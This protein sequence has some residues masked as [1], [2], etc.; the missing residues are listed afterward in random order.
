MKKTTTYFRDLK[1]EFS[2][3]T[4]PDRKTAIRLTA[5]VIIF[6]AAFAAFLGA[7]DYLFGEGVRKL[8][9]S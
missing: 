2:Q 1:A 9:L 5:V 6:S 7:V 8:I 3:I 4:W